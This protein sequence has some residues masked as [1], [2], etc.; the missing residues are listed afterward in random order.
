MTHDP[1]T[2]LA[3]ARGLLREALDYVVYA[4]EV[5]SGRG[6]PPTL[7]PRIRT[8]LAGAAVPPDE[9]RLSADEAAGVQQMLNLA[10]LA[11]GETMVAIINAKWSGD[12]ETVEH[13]KEMAARYNAGI[14]VL[15]A[16]LTQ[17]AGDDGQ[18]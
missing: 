13:E 9:G 15:R 18:G 1:T 7:S 8:H 16:L 12:R 17:K 14:R 2:L 10:T 5:A 6:F 3:E 11:R 4:E